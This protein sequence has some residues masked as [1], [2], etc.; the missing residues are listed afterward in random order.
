LE[1]PNGSPEINPMRDRLGLMTVN[2][3]SL[4]FNGK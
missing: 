1:K 4:L 2:G 3:C